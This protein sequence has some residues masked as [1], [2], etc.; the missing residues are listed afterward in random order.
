[1][2]SEPRLYHRRKVCR[3]QQY[4]WCQGQQHQASQDVPRH[5]ATHRDQHERGNIG[6]RDRK[7]RGHPQSGK[8]LHSKRVLSRSREKCTSRA[9]N[10]EQERR[11]VRR[12]RAGVDWGAAGPAARAS[13]GLGTSPEPTACRISGRRAALVTTSGQRPACASSGTLRHLCRSVEEIRPLNPEA[14][15]QGRDGQSHEQA[16]AQP[17]TTGNSQHRRDPLTAFGI[18]RRRSVKVHAG[19]LPLVETC[20]GNQRYRLVP[21]ELLKNGLR[22]HDTQRCGQLKMKTLDVVGMYVEAHTSRGKAD[23][24]RDAATDL[25]SPDRHLLVVRELQHYAFAGVVRYDTNEYETVSEGLQKRGDDPVG[26]QMSIA[27]TGREL[28]HGIVDVVKGRLGIR[29]HTKYDV[30]YALYLPPVRGR[31]ARIPLTNASAAVARSPFCRVLSTGMGCPVA[32]VASKCTRTDLSRNV[33]GTNRALLCAG[34]LL[35]TVM[36]RLT[37]LRT[38]LTLWNTNESTRRLIHSVELRIVN[39]SSPAELGEP[40]RACA[41][42]VAAAGF[43]ASVIAVPATFHEYP[44]SF[45]A[46]ERI[47]LSAACGAIGAGAGGDVAGLSAAVMLT[48][49]HRRA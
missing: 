14:D 44:A 23:E 35:G 48:R 33:S 38:M 47:G 3:Y 17:T 8:E 25:R 2:K 42:P 26:P 41:L 37:L 46:V 36:S 30:V 18:F 31:P 34:A 16:V 49:P 45:H 43:G 6:A 27:I 13:V 4:G 32:S 7:Q 19:L 29:S 12:I 21:Y 1:M 22:D 15:H 39:M 24:V 11:S 28:C 10:R 9:K 5:R 20:A 40:S